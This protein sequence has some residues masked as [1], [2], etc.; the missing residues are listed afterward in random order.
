MTLYIQLENGAIFQ[1]QA[2]GYF[3]KAVVGD[4]VVYQGMTGYDKAM[5]DPANQGKILVMAYPQV[6]AYGLNM[7]DKESS[8]P[9]VQGLIMRQVSDHP[10]HF[11]CEMNLHHFLTYYK[12]PAVAGVDTRSLV[13]LLREEGPLRGVITSRLLTSSK[14]ARLL[15]KKGPLEE[16][17]TLEKIGGEGL[18]LGIWDLGLKKSSLAYF[19][20]KGYEL[21]LIPPTYTA[22]EVLDL[23]LDGLFMSS[24]PYSPKKDRSQEIKKLLGRLPLCGV[25]LGAQEL[26]LSLESRLEKMGAGVYSPSYPIRDLASGQIHQVNLNAQWA[27][28]DLGPG[29]EALFESVEGGWVQGFSKDHGDLLGLVFDPLGQPGSG[30]LGSLLDTWLERVEARHDNKR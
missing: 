27:I 18:R 29:L 24:G 28:R 25:G 8:R 12:T 16:R 2:L 14:L 20:E 19:K 3:D 11:M 4:L 30:A 1:G 7:E 13:K 17:Q 9:Q 22:E 26:A 23:D 10:S 15:E 6:G 21:F 5:T